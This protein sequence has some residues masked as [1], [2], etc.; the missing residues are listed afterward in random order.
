H[1]GPSVRPGIIQERHVMP[2][3]VTCDQCQAHY[4][5]KDE[6]AGKKVRCKECGNALV[7]PG[8]D[9]SGDGAPSVD[10]G[11]HPAFAPDK[12]LMNQNG[13]SVS[14][15][16][17]IFDERQNPILYIER[18]AHFF[19]RLGAALAGTFVAIFGTLAFVLLGIAL[20]DA[21]GGGNNTLGGAVIIV[22][23]VV[24]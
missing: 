21:Q 1:P 11:Y 8:L 7:V 3:E 17:Y 19:R 9:T 13:I 14:E 10:R 2:V 24:S 6:Y 16:Y 5:L 15:K 18:P 4:T 12:F 22:G 20:G 23:L